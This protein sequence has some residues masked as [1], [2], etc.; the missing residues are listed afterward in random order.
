MSVI[1]IKNNFKEE[2]IKSTIP[3]LVDFNANWC[4]PCQRLKPI[5]EELSE[6]IHSVK[7]VSIDV[8]YERDLAEYYNIMSIPC[9][10]Y[11]VNGEEKNRLVGLKSKEEIKKLIGE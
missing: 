9:L 5:I 10:L 8:D 3:V 2:V 6:E 1:N 11:F 4:G 7:F